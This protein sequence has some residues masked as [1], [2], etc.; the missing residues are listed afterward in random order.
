MTI[1]AEIFGNSASRRAVVLRTLLGA[2]GAAA[3]FAST[4]RAEA[5]MAQSAAGYQETPK[6]SQQCDNCTLFQAPSGCQLVDGTI[7]PAGWCK[8]YAKKPS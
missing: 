7:T 5:K 8:F 2:A 6:G 4:R 1:K 3:L